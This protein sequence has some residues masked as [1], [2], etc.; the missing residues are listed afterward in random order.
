[1]DMDEC[2]VKTLEAK[3]PCRLFSVRCIAM[4]AKH[5]Y[6]LPEPRDQFEHDE[7]V[8]EL[9]GA[10]VEL[11]WEKDP[12]M[13]AESLTQAINRELSN[14]PVYLANMLGWIGLY[15]DSDLLRR[16]QLE[17]AQRAGSQPSKLLHDEYIKHAQV[18]AKP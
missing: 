1:M 10:G 16:E 4:I 12:A 17:H 6:R 9:M 15:L 11:M 5:Q 8:L 18:T 7:A 13:I 2:S 14:Q 3:T